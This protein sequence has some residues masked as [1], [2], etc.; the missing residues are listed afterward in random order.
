LLIDVLQY[1]DITNELITWLQSKTVILT[2]LQKAQLDKTGTALAVIRAVLTRWTAH[3][4][5]YKQLLE[6][7]GALQML[8]FAEN[9]RPVSIK[10]IATGEQK[11]KDHSI[12]MMGVITNSIFWCAIVQ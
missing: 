6:L 4:Q 2:L 11:A 7:Q 5:A 10:L 12:K 8:V 9:A 1:T 3:Y